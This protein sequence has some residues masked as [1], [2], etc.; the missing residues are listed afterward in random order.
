MHPDT[1]H[2]R[3]RLE[4]TTISLLTLSGLAVL[5]YLFRKKFSKVY[6][7]RPSKKID[8]EIRYDA[9]KDADATMLAQN[10]VKI[11]RMVLQPLEK[12]I[13]REQASL[14]Y[15]YGGDFWEMRLKNAS[16]QLK[17]SVR[18][19]LEAKEW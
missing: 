3:S 8:I 19:L 16:E 17:G 10:Q 5:I 12:L 11:I 13:K 18:K 7:A 4:D 9:V 14:I 1:K 2:Q 6:V 15:V